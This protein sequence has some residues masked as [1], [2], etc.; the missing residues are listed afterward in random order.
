[1]EERWIVEAKQNAKDLAKV[2]YERI[3]REA[4]DIC[5][6]RKW[7]FEKVVYYMTAESEE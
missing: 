3:I 7:Y 6:H 5:V 4:D 1:M 2:L